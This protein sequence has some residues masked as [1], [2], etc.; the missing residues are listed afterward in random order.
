MEKKNQKDLPDIIEERKLLPIEIKKFISDNVFFNCVMLIVITAITLIINVSFNK[1]QLKD[2]EKYID[3]IQIFCAI[4]SVV[5]LEVAYRKD[6]GIIAIYGIEFLMF[7]IAVLFVPYMY[8]SKE[9]I[10]FLKIII[11][12]LAVYYVVKS[13]WIYLHKKH[14]YLKENL[15][16]V[17][18]IVKEDKKGYIDEEST[19]TLKVEKEEAELRKKARAEKIKKNKNIKK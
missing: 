2:F 19:K 9:K 15:S 13:L 4:I 12:I 3:I 8:I 11:T 10:Y 7:S 14:T 18:E 16:D 17:K 6:S 1:L 5:I